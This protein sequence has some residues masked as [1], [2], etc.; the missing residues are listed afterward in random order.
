MNP[1]TPFRPNARPLSRVTARARALT[2]TLAVVAA[3]VASLAAPTTAHAAQRLAGNE[4][5]GKQVRVE[6]S[7][8]GSR[9]S[10]SKAGSTPYVWAP[11]GAKPVRYDSLQLKGL[12]GPPNARFALINNQ[13]FRSNDSAHVI[14][15]DGRVQVQCLA[16]REKSA[17]VKV[18]GE[19]EPRE[20]I[21]PSQAPIPIAATPRRKP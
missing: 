17:L 5:D 21:L 1:A 12:S 10:S 11:P 13:S 18:E 2:F 6:P 19:S 9:S 7:R 3:A 16:I 14:V 15:G 4:L 20:L 8:S